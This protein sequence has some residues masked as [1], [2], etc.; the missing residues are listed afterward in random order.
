MSALRPLEP[1]DAERAGLEPTWHG[2]SGGDVHRAG[3]WSGD[4][5]VGAVRLAPMRRLRRGHAGQVHVTASELAH[6][7]ALLA[8]VCAFADEWTALDRLQLEVPADHPAAD[9]AISHGFAVE[10]RRIARLGDG[11]DELGLGRLRPG[12]AP[13]PPG[14]HPPWPPRGQRRPA[15]VSFRPLTAADS[16]GVRDR[17]I[18]PTAVWGTLQT[19]WSNERF[20]AERHATT[21]AENRIVAVVVDGEI[22]GTGGFHPLGIPGVWGLGM[23]IGAR[24]QGCGIG[25]QLL[26]HVVASAWEGGARRL[27]LGVWEDNTRARALYLSRGFVAEGT[28]RC[29]GIRG[30]GHASSVEM[31]LRS[32]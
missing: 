4:T 10:V 12:F 2:P 28:L 31:A 3:L 9:A 26:D 6:A 30:G 19:P 22:A 1:S 5:L 16:T 27:E 23:A 8:G 17:S 21:T 32:P 20:Y 13:R 7:D 15:A 25:A 14:P 11:R 29:D 18:E 24:W